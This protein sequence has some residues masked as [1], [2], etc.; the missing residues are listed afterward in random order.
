MGQLF[1]FRSHACP[2][3][4][5]N[6]EIYTQITQ[7][8]YRNLKSIDIEALRVDLLQSALCK[9]MLPSNLNDLVQ[10]FNDI[11]ALTLE[12]HAPLI[13]KS[14][15]KRPIVP[16]FNDKIKVAKSERRR[17]ERRVEENETRM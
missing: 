1:I 16:W 14:V 9:D 12:R 2:L 17:A 10:C 5:S 4:C 7:I 6:R 15:A 8:S 13:T 11:L 3:Q